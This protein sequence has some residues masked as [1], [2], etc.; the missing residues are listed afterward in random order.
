MK[1][2]ICHCNSV[3]KATIMKA[4]EDGAKT[5]NDIGKITTAGIGNNCAEKNPMGKCCIPEIKELLNDSSP[6]D[7]KCC[8]CK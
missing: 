5:V 3:S 8:C 4:I 6:N 2:I 1:E 7:K